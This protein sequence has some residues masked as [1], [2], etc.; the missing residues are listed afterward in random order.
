MKRRRGE[1]DSV[2]GQRGQ[3]MT[4]MLALLLVLVPLFVIVP[5][6]GKFIDLKQHNIAASRYVAFEAMARHSSAW[7]SWTSD[8][9]LGRDVRRR[10]FSASRAP[11]KTNDAAGDFSAHRN[12]MWTD[13][14]GDPLL[15]AFTAHVSV[16]AG[17]R[18]GDEP[19]G[20]Y[21]ARDL[22]LPQRTLHRADVT[23]RPVAAWAPAGERLSL[24]M[25]QSTVLLAD[26]WGVA[27]GS[28]VG[29]RLHGSSVAFPTRKG[30]EPVAAMHRPLL[31]AM[32]ERRV[33]EA[34][35][36]HPDV[37]PTDRLGEYR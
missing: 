37:I 23:V 9:D 31:E 7:G 4:E 30:I 18:D 20:A 1:H 27:D 33:P 12:P 19:A 15:P 14:R 26:T 3:A 16:H 29:V 5:L 34:G 35:V 24:T 21:L 32:L 2:V 13:Q 25:R 36:V 8:E 17:Q 22:S 10:F 11:I 6:L 28:R